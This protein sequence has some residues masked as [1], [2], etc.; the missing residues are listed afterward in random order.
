MFSSRTLTYTIIAPTSRPT[1]W[2]LPFW[3][4]VARAVVR[5]R[6]PSTDHFLPLAC[7]PYPPH[8]KV[9]RR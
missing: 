2:Y 6:S 8:R 5:G 1:T 4:D 7:L 3:H 9:S